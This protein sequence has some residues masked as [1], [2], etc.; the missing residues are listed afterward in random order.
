MTILDKNL[1]ITYQGTMSIKGRG[2]STWGYPKKPYALKLDKKAE[3]LGMPKHKRWCLLANWMDRTMLR[4]AV[5]FEISRKTGLDWTPRGQFAELVLNGKHL[6]NYYLC[7]Q[8]KVD[9]ERVNIAE[10]DPE[11]TSGDAITGG[12]I[13][14]LDKYYDEVYKFR[15]ARSKMPWMFKDPDE[16]NQAQFDYVKNY[17]EE[18]EEALYDEEKFKNREFVNYMDLESF[19]DWWF[20]NELAMNSEA[21]WPKSV[22]ANKDKNGKIK[23]GPVWDFD[24]GTYTPEGASHFRGKTYLCYPLLFAD[25]EFVRIVKERW[26]AFKPAF[27][28]DIP[29][30]IEEQKEILRESDKINSAMW[31]ISGSKPNGDEDMSYEDAVARMKK[32]FTDKLKWLD[33]KIQAM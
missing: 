25:K 26:A 16:V 32:S 28:S 8:I 14:E 6:G 24:W 17:V 23:A 12:Y 33:K 11:A 29:V 9:K 13:F 21:S 22:Y 18:M 10:L 7:E 2:N 3:I 30:F 1:E 19:A 31:P 20:I 15:P 27:E 4:N 5:T